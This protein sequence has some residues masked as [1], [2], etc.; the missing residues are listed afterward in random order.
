M[1]T[2]TT[3]SGTTLWN[4][5]TG[6]LIRILPARRISSDQERRALW[7]RTVE[8]FPD[9]CRLLTWGRDPFATVWNAL[10]GEELCDLTE[11]AAITVARVFPDGSRVVTGGFDSRTVIWDASCSALHTLVDEHWVTDIAVLEGGAIV[12]TATASGRATL[13]SARTGRLLRSLGS[14]VGVSHGF[15]VF[16]QGD[17]LASFHATSV[18]IW[19][20]SS[21][22]ALLRIRS[23][24]TLFQGVAVSPGGD[25]FATCGGGEVVVWDV[26]SGSRLATFRDAPA[27]GQR[28]GHPSSCI[29]TFGVGSALDPRGFGRGL[30]RR[31]LPSVADG[32]LLERASVER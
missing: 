31:R 17:R 25:I 30:P 13:W 20:A 29:L 15:A 23:A 5:S 12:A 9:E 26:A 11:H 19:N 6:E 8:V 32:R 24:S 2:T 16:P 21:G 3:R 27:K 28:P 4:A 1:A 7:T 14:G 10:T 22:E 18:V